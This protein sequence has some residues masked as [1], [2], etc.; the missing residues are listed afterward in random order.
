[1]SQQALRIVREVASRMRYEREPTLK[2]IWQTLEVSFKRKRGDCED[3][4][5][6]VLTLCLMAGIRAQMFCT[7][8]K[9]R[10]GGRPVTEGHAVCVGNGWY[11]S[12]GEYHRTDDFKKHLSR[13]YGW[14]SIRA[15]PISLSY[16]KNR[17][18]RI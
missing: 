6:A 4:A 13:A 18:I 9:R 8:G 15:F 1:M 17:G 14:E 2:D 10:K 5:I 16:L 12:N 11:S 3:F 7:Y